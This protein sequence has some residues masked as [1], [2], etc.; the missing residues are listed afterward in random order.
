[1]P[2]DESSEPVAIPITGELDLHT[3]RPGDVPSLLDAYFAECRKS[4]IRR[5]RVVHGKG[6]GT[7]RQ[8][9]REAL[10]ENPLVTSFKPGAREEG[11]DGVTIAQLASLA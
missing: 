7:L 5:V 4:G 10:A 11:G 8:V 6:T 9:V 1:M 3:F 2:T